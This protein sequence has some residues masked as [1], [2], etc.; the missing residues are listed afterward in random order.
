MAYL[1][2]GFPMNPQPP[3]P[4]IP[5]FLQ[6]TAPGYTPNVDFQLNPLDAGVGYANRDKINAESQRICNIFNEWI[7][8]QKLKLLGNANARLPELANENTNRDLLQGLIRDMAEMNVNKIQMT[9]IINNFGQQYCK[10]VGELN[11]VES[12]RQ[13]NEIEKARLFGCIFLPIPHQRHLRACQVAVILS[14]SGTFGAIVAIWSGAT[15]L[16]TSMQAA[17]TAGLQCLIMG[18]I[19]FI[20]LAA[21]L[22]S[23]YPTWK[24]PILRQ[25]Y[26][27]D[28]MFVT[29]L[30][31]L[32][33]MFVLS[34]II[35]FGAWMWTKSNAVFNAEQD[36]YQ[37]NQWGQKIGKVV[38][39]KTLQGYYTTTY[40]APAVYTIAAK[41]ANRLSITRAA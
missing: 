13:L 27:R 39:G 29:R 10:F 30:W 31:D 3:A 32:Y 9:G 14:V 34:G 12:Q 5:P 33:M 41:A 37:T 15:A 11:A 8:A 20:C 35:A 40:M 19:Q 18:L 22:I 21:R 36:S 26:G 6:Q 4:N 1:F 23:R 7:R 16:S 2:S 24:I 38:A 25:M 28:A 17:K